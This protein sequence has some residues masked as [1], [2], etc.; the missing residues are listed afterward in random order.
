M[1]I[2][3]TGL[4]KANEL[5]ATA[6]SALSKHLFC[7]LW[8]TERVCFSIQSTHTVQKQHHEQT[9]EELK[10]NR[11]M[12]MLQGQFSNKLFQML[13]A[14]SCIDT[15]VLKTSVPRLGL[16]FRSWQ[17]NPQVAFF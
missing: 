3:T 11:A 14:D 10:N 4:A 1:H 5:D 9:S 16:G 6:P 8:D 12:L 13:A 2:Y 15:S 7:V 17:L